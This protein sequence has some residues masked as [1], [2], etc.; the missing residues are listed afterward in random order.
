MRLFKGWKLTLMAGMTLAG[1]HAHVLAQKPGSLD[2]AP[3]GQNGLRAQNVSYAGQD[4]GVPTGGIAGGA[5]LA[6]GIPMAGPG[7]VPGMGPMGPGMAPPMG[8]PGMPPM[9]GPGM[10]PMGGPGMPPMGPGMAPPMAGPYGPEGMGGPQPCPECGGPCPGCGGSHCDVFGRDAM[11]LISHVTGGLAKIPALFVPFG[12]GGIAT[13]R[14]Y[15]AK[16]E[17]I[18]MTRTSG[19]SNF[20]TSSLGAGT[21]DFVLGTGMVAPNSMQGGLGLQANVQVGPGSNL[22]AIYW[23][24]DTWS[25]SAFA[26]SPAP[27]NLYSFISNFGTFPAGGFD[28]SDRSLLHTLDYTS[29]L[30]NGE[31]NFRR[32][33]SEPYG[34][35]QGSFLT[36]IRYLELVET[37]RFTATGL[38]N[39]GAA[40][41]GPRFFDYDL[42]TRNALVGWQVGGDLWYNFRPGIKL[43]VELKTGIF[44]NRS[45]Q[46]TTI[47]A[48][49]LPAFGI[50]EIRESALNNETAYV[51]QLSPQMVYRLNYSWAFRSS[52]E[53]LWMDNVALASDNFN[54]TAPSVISPTAS[55]IARVNTDANVVYQGFT[56]GAEFTW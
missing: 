49:S 8:G 50:P 40:N 44:N 41:N 17:G 15:D 38:N 5:H 43:G 53:V 28:D 51:T 13:Q 42:G 25:D 12:E 46:N 30:Q 56:A 6:E 54:A 18:G 9:G 27:G 45:K 36:G 22:E 35:F 10:P 21:G 52:Y 14:W 55:R 1:S 26:T 33:W 11:G 16:I 24:L 19:N 23:G 32:R 34:F 39:N 2:M 37:S 4:Y 20:N 31:I 3:M 47:F 29:K 7:P 48:N